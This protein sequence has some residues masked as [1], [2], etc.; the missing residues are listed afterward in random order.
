M[1]KCLYCNSDILIES[2]EHVI[3]NAIGGHLTSVDI[4]CGSCNNLV[5]TLIDSEFTNALS[6]ITGRIPDLNKSYSKKRR[7]SYRGKAQDCEGNVY[8]V[9]IKNKAI[10]KIINT[11][12]DYK[13]MKKE[14]LEIVDFHYEVKSPQF[15]KGI[16]KIALNFAISRNLDP[17]FIKDFIVVDCAEKINSIDYKG[18]IYQFVPVNHFDLMLEL[19]APME[20]YHNLVLFNNGST[21]WCYIDLFNTFQYYVKLS[22]KYIDND[23]Y[24]T[25]FRYLQKYDRTIAKLRHKDPKFVK[26]M[27]ELQGFTQTG[28]F[29]EYNKKLKKKAHLAPYSRKY[30]DLMNEKIWNLEV[31]EDTIEPENEEDY[32]IS[33]EFYLNEIGLRSNV[34]RKKGPLFVNNQFIDIEMPELMSTN[35]PDGQWQNIYQ[36]LKLD[37]LNKYLD[38][39]KYK[40]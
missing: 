1:G 7:Q 20:L 27:E 37:R 24:E 10:T 21:L 33:K 15:L 19:N 25:H 40:D 30:D 9:F 39:M 14:D 23:I 5:Q 16:K 38:L 32:F 13:S 31:W 18:E 36:E 2:K 35:D 6:P 4:C 3:H 11:N 8:D 29:S 28:D 22:S 34:F 17:K 12:F 26:F